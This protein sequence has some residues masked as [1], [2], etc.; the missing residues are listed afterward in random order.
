[1]F[2]LA[3]FCVFS[4]WPKKHQLCTQLTVNIIAAV[5][6]ERDYRWLHGSLISTN[7]LTRDVREGKDMLSF[8][9]LSYFE[10]SLR[11]IEITL[12]FE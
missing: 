9:I 10:E 1:M 12:V 7:F 8:E 6:S 5:T 4:R 2:R 11:N 3:G